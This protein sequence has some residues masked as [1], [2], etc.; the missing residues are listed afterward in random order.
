MSL[1]T[2][3][4]VYPYH[5]SRK[6]IGLSKMSLYVEAL[7][8]LLTRAYHSPWL[9]TSNHNPSTKTYTCENPHYRTIIPPPSN[10]TLYYTQYEVNVLSLTQNILILENHLLYMTYDLSHKVVHIVEIV[11]TSLA[12]KL[13]SGPRHAVCCKQYDSAVRPPDKKYLSHDHQEHWCKITEE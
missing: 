6:A 5:M 3:L 2:F 10:V 1:F 4:C 11:W 8:F 9:T 7:R 13:L 12:R